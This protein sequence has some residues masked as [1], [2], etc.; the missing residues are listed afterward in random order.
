MLAAGVVAKQPSAL[1]LAARER[2]AR[3]RSWAVATLRELGR[4][5]PQALSALGELLWEEGGSKSRDAAYRLWLNAESRGNESAC[6]S[7]AKHD[8]PEGFGAIQPR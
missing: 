7:L 3:E 6:E 5:R 1:I 8:P 2:F 4:S